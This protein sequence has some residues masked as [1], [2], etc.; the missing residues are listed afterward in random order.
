[1]FVRHRQADDTLLQ[2][3]VA[4]RARSLTRLNCAESRDD[5]LVEGGESDVELPTL[6]HPEGPR[7]FQRG[8]G[9]RVQRFRSRVVFTRHRQTKV[10]LLQ[11][12]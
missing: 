9:S 6:R 2:R 7:F 12:A 3:A 1:M 8:E 5:A 4:N 10:Q 11:T